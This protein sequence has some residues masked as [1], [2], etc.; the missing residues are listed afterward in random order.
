VEFAQTNRLYFRLAMRA[1]RIKRGSAAPH[2]VH[3]ILALYPEA[4]RL[5]FVLTSLRIALLRTGY[6][7]NMVTVRSG[8]QVPGAD[9]GI[10][11]SAA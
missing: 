4:R 3:R 5:I 11:A 2:L 6:L 1:A 10:A 8:R 9:A 7:W